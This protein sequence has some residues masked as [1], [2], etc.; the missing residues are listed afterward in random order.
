[1]KRFFQKTKEQLIDFI[2]NERELNSQIYDHLNSVIKLDMNGNL[3][4]YNQA[5]AKQYGYNEQDFKKPFLDVFIK[6]ETCEQKQFFE[7]AILGRSQSF[8]AIGR[9]RNGKTVDIN[10][11][12]LPIKAKADMDVYV[13][14]KNITKY[15]EQEKEML[16]FQKKQDIFNELENICDF[17][18]DAINDCHHFSKQLSSIFGIDE[19]KSFLHHLIN[20]YNMFILTIAIE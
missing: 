14:V 4:T 19:G 5:F 6:Y 20:Y 15:K 13:I 1:M 11:T 16:L 7:K 9:C 12:L 17:Y 3:I 2:D 8:N 10:V 18:Y